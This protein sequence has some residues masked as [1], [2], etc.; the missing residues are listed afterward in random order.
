MW[1]MVNSVSG[2]QPLSAYEVIYKY[3]GNQHWIYRLVVG[4]YAE[5]MRYSRIKDG[6]R[7]K[8]RTVK[9]ACIACEVPPQCRTAY[10]IT[11]H[12]EDEYALVELLARLSGAED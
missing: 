1:N 5:V 4:K 3:Q 7:F 12:A 8:V 2:Y 9:P 10:V 11:H 6:I